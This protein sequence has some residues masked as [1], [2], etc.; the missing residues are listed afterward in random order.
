MSEVIVA[1]YL[2][3]GY[4]C[5]NCFHHIGE[6]LYTPTCDKNP[7]ERV[8]EK[9]HVAKLDIAITMSR[10]VGRSAMI[11]VALNRWGFK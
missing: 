8:C 1:K 9:Y 10:Q 5:D 3:L 7:A 2:L 11:N 6:L 4:N